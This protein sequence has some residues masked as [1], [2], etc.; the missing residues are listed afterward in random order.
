M[1]GPKPPKA[2]RDDYDR[3]LRLVGTALRGE[4]P[5]EDVEAAAEA[6]L[7]ALATVPVPAKGSSRLS[8]ATQLRPHRCFVLFLL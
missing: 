2:A 8:T 7:Q 1:L 6:L 5:F 3:C 4:T